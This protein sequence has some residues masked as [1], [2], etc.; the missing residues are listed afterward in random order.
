MEHVYFNNIDL[1]RITNLDE[2]DE[3]LVYRIASSLDTMQTLSLMLRGSL[4]IGE[5]RMFNWKGAKMFYIFKCPSHGFQITY[6]TGY[7]DLLQCIS[8]LREEY[9]LKEKNEI[10]QLSTNTS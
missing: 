1:G 9:D 10:S 8:C 3:K 4:E 5:L 6:R 2:I 7:S